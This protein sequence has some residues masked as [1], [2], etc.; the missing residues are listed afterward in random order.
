MTELHRLAATASLTAIYSLCK[1][2]AGYQ[3][4][5]AAGVP[6]L[7]IVYWEKER[8]TACDVDWAPGSL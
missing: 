3:G 7:I 2:Q 5:P 6:P 4:L 8:L 1:S